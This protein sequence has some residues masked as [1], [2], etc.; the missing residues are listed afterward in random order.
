MNDFDIRVPAYRHDPAPKHDPLGDLGEALERA[1]IWTGAKYRIVASWV[2]KNPVEAILW[3]FMAFG[4]LGV[5]RLTLT[6]I[7]EHV[8]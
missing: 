7:T 6:A 1:S 2:R 3:A 8:F 5:L 4:S